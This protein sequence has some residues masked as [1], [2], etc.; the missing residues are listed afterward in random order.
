MPTTLK[1]NEMVQLWRKF[2]A[3]GVIPKP[4]KKV[5]KIPVKQLGIK[6]LVIVRKG[7][8]DPRYVY[9]DHG[10][11]C[12]TIADFLGGTYTD[13]EIRLRC[14]CPDCGSIVERTHPNYTIMWSLVLDK[15]IPKV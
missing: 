12:I 6:K 7:L 13:I 11:D 10:G 5:I 15:H 8:P 1:E 9:C 3:T 4:R 14:Y 2:I